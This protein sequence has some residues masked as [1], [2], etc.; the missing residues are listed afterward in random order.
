MRERKHARGGRDGAQ[1]MES[2]MP[3]SFDPCN[4]MYYINT[5]ATISSNVTV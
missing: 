2:D 1:A 3:N 5:I 4:T